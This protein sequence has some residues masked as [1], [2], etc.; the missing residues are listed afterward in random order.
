VSFSSLWRILWS[1]YWFGVVRPFGVSLGIFCLGFYRLDRRGWWLVVASILIF[2]I[3]AFVTYSRHD[4]TELYM[5]WLDTPRNIAELQMFT[6][7]ARDRRW[8]GFPV[9]GAVPLLRL[10]PFTCGVFFLLESVDVG[11]CVDRCKDAPV[12]NTSGSHA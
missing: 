10:P 5:R 7:L 3:S 4:L 2:S 8:R 6:F 1:V 12:S 11:F 9:I